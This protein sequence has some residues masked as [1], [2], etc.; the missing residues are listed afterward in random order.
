MEAAAAEIEREQALREGAVRE[1]GAMEQ[2]L[3]YKEGMLGALQEA[4][5][6]VSGGSVSCLCTEGS[7]WDTR[8]ACWARC[9]RQ[10][11]GGVG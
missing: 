2:L 6:G 10:L 8:R 11:R 1:R 4:A 3:D 9:R 5:E 7:C